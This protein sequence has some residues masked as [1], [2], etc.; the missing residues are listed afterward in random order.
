MSVSCPQC[1][2]PLNV[3]GLKPGQFKPKCPKC[4]IAFVLVVPSSPDGT[5]VT[6]LLPAGPPKPA[7][8]PHADPNS[9]GAFTDVEPPASDTTNAYSASVA[10]WPSPDATGDFT[11]PEPAANGTGVFAPSGVESGTHGEPAEGTQNF[12][13]SEAPPPKRKPIASDAIPDRLGGYEVV[14]V[15]GQGGMG[16]V[17]LGRQVSLGRKVALKIMHPKLSN[18]A[19]FVARFTREAYAAA[20]MTHHNV[21]QIY[22]IGEDHGTHFFSMEFVPGQSLMDLVKEK[23]KLDPEAAVGYTLQAARGLRFGHAQGMVH[24]DIKPDNLML[25]TEGI[26]KVADLGLVKLPTP[27]VPQS[28]TAVEDDDEGDGRLTRAGSVM[29]TPMYMPP[30]QAMNSA[31]VDHRADIYSLG[32]SLYVMLT[33]KPPFDGKTALEVITRH[34]TD[35]VVPPDVIVKRVPKALSGILVKMLAKRPDDR[36]Q[37]MDEVI[38][39]LE[40]YLGVKAV[41]P[42]TP[43]EEHAKQLE[44]AAQRFNAAS[45]R[46]LKK[47]AALGLVATCLLGVVACGLAGA[48][49]WAGGF[50]GLLLATPVAYFVVAGVNS[51]SPFFAKVRQLVFGS[52]IAD[53]LTWAGG[54]ILVLLA[55]WVFGILWHFLG[56]AA[57][58]VGLAFVLWFL[59]DRA[60]DSAREVPV[61][62]A[63]VLFKSMRLQG[64]D[65][66]NVRQFVCKYAGDDWE[67]LY[68]SL[69]GYEAKLAAREYRKGAV[70]ETARKFAA[71]REPLIAGLDARMRSRQ[72]A[73]ERKHLAKVEAKALE[74]KGVGAGEAREQADAMADALVGEAVEAKAAQRAGK[75]ADLRAM[76]KAAKAKKP[77]EGYNLAGV[78]RRSMAVQ[79]LLN[80]WAGRRLRFALGAAVFAIGLL[81]LSQNRDALKGLAATVEQAV[82]KGDVTAAGDAA[83]SATKTMA[84]MKPLKLAVLPDAV[85]KGVSHYGTPICGFLLML[86]GI[87]YYGWKPSLVAVPGVVI[88]V[89]GP[90][91][92]VPDVEPLKAWMLST[93]VGGVL[94][95]VAGRFLRS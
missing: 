29:G 15:L 17:L 5:I 64:L 82:E 38:A 89:L 81:W 68:E 10:A 67:E 78:K 25:N 31:G 49:P 75:K 2:S 18:D 61:N 35:P 87:L 53:W 46:G 70:A 76:V 71:W 92:G 48:F 22:D 36:Y 11:A 44:T 59:T 74:A 77:P 1:R 23:G 39:A 83:K 19:K 95:L 91:L 55:L 16:A 63:K 3:K 80:D 40:G 84:V 58:G 41:G 27:D 7:P 79:N 88:G 60:Q 90:T 65:E 47:V 51:P 28:K 50:L 54:A 14:K 45:K 30:E 33:G 52:R 62:D 57:L 56:G 69:F 34:Q 6:K 13:A 72:E 85:A 73:K 43:K 86:S 32:C 37:T 26:V 93:L 20:Q 9:T 4:G 12:E 42:F 66:E 21:I 24:R 94:I 8:Q